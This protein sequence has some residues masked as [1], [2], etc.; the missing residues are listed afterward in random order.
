[1]TSVSESVADALS[2][3]AS[4]LAVS[5]AVLPITSAPPPPARPMAPASAVRSLFQAGR[6]SP[7]SCRLPPRAVAVASEVSVPPL[8]IVSAPSP[9]CTPTVRAVA[10]DASLPTVS[11]ARVPDAVAEPTL[12][13]AVASSAAWIVSVSSPAPPSMPVAV[14]WASTLASAVA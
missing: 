9:P 10:F 13:D 1:M 4:A 3:C 2:A 14:A 5:A 12:A 7:V 6:P 11:P 8:A